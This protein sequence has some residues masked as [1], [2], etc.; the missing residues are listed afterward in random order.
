MIPLPD[1]E[2]RS[3]ENQRRCYIC[4]KRFTKNNKKVRDHC[5]FTGKYRGAAHNK[6]N[7]NHKITKNIPVI[8]HNG[9]TYDYHF[10]IKELV[11][12]FEG[13]FECLGE[14]TEK[15]I[16][17]SISINKKN[18]KKDKNGNDRIVNIPYRLEFVDGYRFMSAPLSSLVD[19]LSDGLHKCENCEST[20]EY[21]NAENSRVIFK[22]LY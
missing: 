10:I 17:F 21:I 8:F 4:K 9:S 18:T 5:H 1:K 6:C 11:K 3:Y 19:N 7:M 16:T 20:L 15:Y 14:N 22:C 2:N 13:E 12:E